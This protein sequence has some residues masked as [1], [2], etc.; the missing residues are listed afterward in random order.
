M[1]PK[2]KPDVLMLCEIFDIIAK[3]KKLNDSSKIGVLEAAKFTI[4]QVALGS[5]RKERKKSWEE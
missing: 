2:S 5:A 3:Y 1:K 4:L